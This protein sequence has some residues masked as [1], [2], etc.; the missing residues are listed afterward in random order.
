MSCEL[1]AGVVAAVASVGNERNSGGGSARDCFSG[2]RK[3]AL[4][5][6]DMMV[7]V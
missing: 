7:E 5:L 2:M 3:E 6:K 4:V 1:M